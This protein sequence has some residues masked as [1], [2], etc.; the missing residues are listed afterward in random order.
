MQVDGENQMT[1]S[2]LRI[3]KENLER[4]IRDC[5]DVYSKRKI[6]KIR[7]EIVNCENMLTY[8]YH[9]FDNFEIPVSKLI[10]KSKM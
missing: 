7:K 6:G 3:Y 1:K 4:E 10:F 5:S 2:E 8:L 9:Q